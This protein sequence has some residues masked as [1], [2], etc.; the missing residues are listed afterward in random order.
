VEEVCESL[1]RRVFSK[2]KG[3]FGDSRQASMLLFESNVRLDTFSRYTNI[4]IALL[5]PALRDKHWVQISNLVGIS[6]T[7][8]QAL[9]L[10]DVM[11]LDLEVVQDIVGDI[12][13]D[14]SNDLKVIH[15]FVNCSSSK[16]V[17]KRSSRNWHQKNS[18]QNS[19][20]QIAT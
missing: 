4:L 6:R 2:L 1:I 13:I 11:E 18:K 9:Q 20:T 15:W 8:V 10:R 12:S 16:Q 17:W 3:K 19:V 5:N 14:A 7:Q